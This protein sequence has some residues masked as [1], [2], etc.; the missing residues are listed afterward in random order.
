MRRHT[1]GLHSEIAFNQYVE[2]IHY[3][4]II[5]ILI[6]LTASALQVFASAGDTASTA[7]CGGDSVILFRFVPGNRTFYSPFKGNDRAIRLATQLIEQH[8]AAIEAG[9]AHILI[10]GFCSSFAT[11]HEN[12]AAAKER[13]N[14]VKSWFITHQGMKEDYYRTV[15]STSSYQGCN[16]VVALMGLRYAENYSQPTTH[17]AEQADSLA[18]NRLQADTTAIQ[19]PEKQAA[20]QQLSA[21]DSLHLTAQRS[22]FFQGERKPTSPETTYTSSPWYLKSNLLYNVLLMPSLEVEYRIDNRWSVAVEG[23]MA[24]WHNNSKHRYYQLATIVPEVRYW[25]HPQSSRRGHY[26]GIFGGGGWYDLENGGN[27]YKGEGGMV[28]MSYGYMF[29]VGRHLAFEAGIG[30]GFMT[31][32]YEEYQ[33]LDGHYVYQQTSRFNYFGPLRLKLALVWNI[34][35][36]AEKKGGRQ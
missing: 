27:G 15:N 11:R 30:L 18:P 8:R 2:M 4:R 6:V 25:F 21:T 28:G 7:V 17:S 14:H 31:T 3:L 24:W 13:S 26:L 1:A 35:C 10:R 32:K 34:G 36:Q 22:S 12:L 20:G 19:M 9:H 33:P 29:P 5:G 23:S 16:E